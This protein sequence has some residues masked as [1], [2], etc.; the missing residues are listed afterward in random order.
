MDEY[1]GAGFVDTFRHFRP[2]EGGHYSWWS[3]RTNARERNV[4]WRLDYH[5]VDPSFLPAVKS[6]LIRSEVTGSDHC[7]V[8]IELAL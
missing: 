7:P 8:E 1:T 3:Y 2:G 5:C 4:G 6:S